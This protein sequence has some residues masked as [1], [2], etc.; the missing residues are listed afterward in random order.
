MQEARQER[1]LPPFAVPVYSRYR[2]GRCCKLHRS[3]ACLHGQHDWQ[4]RLSWLCF[5]GC[6][7]PVRFAFSD[8]SR[9]IP[10]WCFD[11]GPSRDDIGA[12]LK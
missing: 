10:G 3:W 8:R 6:A 11:W 4:Y 9:R 5:S 2:L 1:I 7:R 12:A